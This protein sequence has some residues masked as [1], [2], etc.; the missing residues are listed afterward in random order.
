MKWYKKQMEQLKAAKSDAAE[1]NKIAGKKTHGHSFVS[2]KRGPKKMSK[3]G[4][5]RSRDKTDSIS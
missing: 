5:K 1:P 4:E 2:T 3:P